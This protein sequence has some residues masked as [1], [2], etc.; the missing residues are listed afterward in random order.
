MV[1]NLTYWRAKECEKTPLGNINKEKSH[2][3]SC[4]LFWSRTHSFALQHV[5]FCTM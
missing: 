5:E 4:V 2:F 1:Q 3:S